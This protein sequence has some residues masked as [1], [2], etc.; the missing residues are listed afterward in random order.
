MTMPG[1]DAFDF[2]SRLSR[3]SIRR[4]CIIKPSAFGD[5]VQSMPILNVLRARFPDSQIS[6]VINRELSD[7]LTGHPADPKLIPFDRRGGVSD[8]WR[9][10]KEIRQSRFD[11]V[12]DLQGLLRTGVMCAASGAPLRVG[13][14]TARESSGLACHLL[15]PNTTTQI[16]AHRRAWAI[17]DALGMG[18]FRQQA[19][20]SVSDV[21]LAWSNQLKAKAG[22]PLL[23]I[24]PG[25]RWQTKQWPIRSFSS[26][27]VRAL[28]NLGMSAI[29]VG[30]RSEASAAEELVQLVKN[31]RPSSE[32]R[33]LAGQT[34]MK[35]LAALM[36]SADLVLSN[37]S[38]PM[39]LAAAMG[40]PVVGIFTCTSP[41]RSGPPGNSHR[42]VSANVSCAAS[43]C[44]QCPKKGSGHLACFRELTP[45]QV[46]TALRDH[47]GWISWQARVAS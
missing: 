39:H 20:L 17:A 33:S 25:A 11:L 26:V 44:K 24:H 1:T 18:N 41:E 2:E 42:L 14:Q 30:S 19:D 4:I 35:Q 13:L 37:D 21:D 47:W 40:T 6:W 16:P 32:I 9:L 3:C 36:R 31:E 45:E 5:V 15:L 28:Q 38:G 7:L 12:F 34:S 43:Y 27:A 29:V 8:W 10:L 23:V 46:W 22:G